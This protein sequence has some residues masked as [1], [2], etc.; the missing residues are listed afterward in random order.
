VRH[1][2]DNGELYLKMYP[3]FI[4]WINECP[5]CHTKGYKPEMP[6]H[7]GGENSIAA[8]NIRKYFNE[9]E[10]DDNG[11]CLQCSKIYNQKKQKD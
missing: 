5:I 10:V 11:F 4:K 3:E 1:K 6:E 8:K 7:I 2:N 9:L